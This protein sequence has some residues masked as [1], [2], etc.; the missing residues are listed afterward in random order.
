MNLHCPSCGRFLCEVEAPRF[1]YLRTRC[2]NCKE[3]VTFERQGEE[4]VTRRTVEPRHPVAKP[5]DLR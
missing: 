5:P 2:H 1:D 4:L 3:S